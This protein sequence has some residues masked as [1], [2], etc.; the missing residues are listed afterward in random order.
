MKTSSIQKAL[1][2]ILVFFTL[3][4]CGF[5]PRFSA[6]QLPN[7][8]DVIAPDEPDE[9]RVPR[10]PERSDRGDDPE[11]LPDYEGSSVFA[12]EQA[13]MQIYEEVSPSVVHIRVVQEALLFDLEDPE[14]EL[15]DDPDFEHPDIP[16]AQVVGSGFIYDTEGHIVTNNHVVDGAQRIIVTFSD[17]TEAAA[18][19]VGSDSDSDLAVIQVDADA[20]L[21]VPVSLGNSDSLKVGQVVVAIG[22][23]FGL[24]NSLTTGVVSGLGRMLPAGAIT[25]SGDVYNIPDIIQTDTVINPGNSGGPLLNLTGEVIGVNTAISTD[26]GVYSGIGYAVPSAIVYQVVPQLISGGEVQ[27][28]RLGIRGGTLTSDMADAMGLDPD[29]HGALVSEVIPDGPA[30][31][32]GLLGSSGT[33]TIDGITTPIGGDIITAINDQEV[34]LFDDL[35]TYIVRETEVGET[36]TLTILRDGEEM[37]VEATLD[38]RT[39]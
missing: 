29:Q 4:A 33:V 34:R 11:P 6:P 26:T 5:L 15:P 2:L 23:P 1:A 30:D 8:P 31:K 19:L 39:D 24:K 25:P 21:L 32:A 3:T 37:Q 18:E 10:V 14:F 27:H 9:E 7:L 20:D 38:A 16:N 22:N 13:F 12:Q 35:L 17:G 36:V 28:P